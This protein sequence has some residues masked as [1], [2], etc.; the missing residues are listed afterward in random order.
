MTDWSAH[1]DTCKSF[2]SKRH[3]GDLFCLR[4]SEKDPKLQEILADPEAPIFRCNEAGHWTGATRESLDKPWRPQPC[5]ACAREEQKR[6]AARR[7]RENPRALA[8]VDVDRAVAWAL[9]LPVFAELIP[10]RKRGRRLAVSVGHKGERRWSG[11]AKPYSFAIRIA[12]GPDVVAA[13]VLEIVVHELSH[14]ATPGHGHDERFRRV[15]QRAFREAWG[16][17]VPIDPERGDERAIAY[18]M[19]RSAMQQ[20]RVKIE[21]GEVRTFPSLPRGPRPT[22]AELTKT[23][24][25]RRAA[26][27]VTMLRRAERRLKIAKSVHRRWAKKVGYYERQAAKKGSK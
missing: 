10:K 18:A 9:T 24:V 27:A 5:W 19:D 25:E 2:L 4:C 1:C 17:E 3:N 26:H 14:V 16:I 6:E 22:R 7:R 23:T 13:E 15:L 8:G 11:H 21:Q 20:L 12:G